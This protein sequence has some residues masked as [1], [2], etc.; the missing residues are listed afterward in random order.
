MTD[1][2]E[3]LNDEGFAMNRGVDSDEGYR[4][5]SRLGIPPTVNSNGMGVGE[6]N[7]TNL[8]SKMMEQEKIKENEIEEENPKK[9]ELDNGDRELIGYISNEL[10][11]P[12]KK[13]K[14]TII[15]ET[16]GGKD[17]IMD[18]PVGELISNTSMVLNNFDNEFLSALHKVDIE[19]GYTNSGNSFFTNFKR[20]TMAFMRYLQEGNN[21]L[22]IGIT[23]FM[24]SIILY[25]INIIRRNDKST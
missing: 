1:I 23:L 12:I 2:E 10:Y 8:Y 17:G 7:S 6:Y 25:F 15:K 22:Y 9:Y 14:K 21:I 19:F 16:G 11:Y 13:D 20:Y 18:I 24:I 3:R 5:L 4:V